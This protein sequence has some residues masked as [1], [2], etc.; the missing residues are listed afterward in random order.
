MQKLS[1]LNFTLLIFLLSALLITSCV[2]VQ[3]VGKLNMIANRNVDSSL[4]YKPISTYSGAEFRN[5]RYTRATSIEEAVDQTVRN[6]PGGEF[7]MNVKIYLVNGRYFAVE[8]DV[9]GR[10]D[11]I[12]YKGFQVG[13]T[14]SWKSGR[15]YISGVITSLKDG[16][17][18]LVELDSGVIK[19]VQYSELT[20]IGTRN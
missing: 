20:K 3:Q 15:E 7:L 6:T 4:D 13:D 1:T 19:E 9:W 2:T 8:G 16:F 14:V 5:L 12:V 18:C 17:R 11:D 10:T